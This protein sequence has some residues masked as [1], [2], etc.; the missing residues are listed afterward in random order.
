MSSPK[1]FISHRQDD[2]KI[3]NVVSNHLREWGVADDA[4]FQSTDPRR[5]LTPG[6]GV[7][8]ELQR[9]LEEVNMLILVY[10]YAEEDW[11]FCMW[12]CGIAQGQSTMKTRTIVLQCT[13]DE[14][15]VFKNEMR[16][17]VQPQEIRRFAEDFHKKPGFFPSSD[18]SLS[19][20]FAKDT[21]AEVITTR[22]ERL[23]SDLEAAIPSGSATSKHLWDFIRLRLG[24]RLM[25]KVAELDDEDAI[26]RI[27]EENLELRRPR[28]VGIGNSVDTAV[29]QFG[30]GS[31]EEGLKL[32]DLIARWT[33]MDSTKDSQWADELYEAIYRAVTNSQSAAAASRFRSVREDADWWFLPAVTRMRGLRDLSVE[34]DVYLVRVPEK[35]TKPT[36][37]RKIVKKSSAKKKAKP[38]PRKKA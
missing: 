24:S 26:K 34:F 12:E 21:S 11:S 31:Y 27:I 3:A 1:I 2:V 5:G 6:D 18:S 25:K 37:A 32:S 9:R 13:E 4:I 29:R 38:R 20:P 8:D 7:K 15:T 35:P 17:R 16:V 30:F 22:G 14:P 36:R 23:F 10:T 33:K 19:E 28:Y